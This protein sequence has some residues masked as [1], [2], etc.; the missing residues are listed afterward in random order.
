M[1]KF[2][3]VA[4]SPFEMI[5]NHEGNPAFAMNDKEKLVSQVLTSFFRED[6]F[7]GDN[8]G[9]LIETLKRV[10]E[11]DPG[12]VSNLAIFARREFNMRSVSHVLTGYLA[13]EPAGKPYVKRTLENIIM[14]GDDATEILAFYLETFGK[15]I[16]N[17]LRKGLRDIF[18]KFDAYTLA[19]YKGTGKTV[20]MRDILCLTHPAPNSEEQAKTWKQLL[21]GTLPPAYTWETELS[22]KGNTKET[23]EELIESGKVGYMAMLRNLRNILISAPDNFNQVIRKIADPEEVRKSRQLP[24]R[25]LSAY[26]SIP[27]IGKATDIIA[28]Q[29]ALEI[30]AEIAVENLPKIPGK[31]I[32]AVDVSGSMMDRISKHSDIRCSDISLLM[33]MIANRICEESVVYLF[34]HHIEEFQPPERKELLSA[35]VN[36]DVWGGGTDMSLPFLKMIEDHIDC[37]RIIILSDNECNYQCSITEEDQDPDSYFSWLRS[38]DIETVQTLANRYCK[39]IGHK[40]WIHAVD[41][42]GYG[43]QQFRGSQVN[44]ISGWSEKIFN[45]IPLAEQ[46]IDSLI[47]RIDG[48]Y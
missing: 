24:F 7:Y 30:A 37:D 22:A 9:E 36:M 42:Q 25:F 10:I 13:H 31:T 41:L 1:S 27:Y 19:K 4:S 17:S 40:I 6:K 32:I 47:T 46:G 43:T 15:P 23:W 33:G 48:N 35:V 11:K 16:P 8:S 39:Q 44:Y 38:Q 2:N 21:E 28:L 20:K 12:F 18:P 5:V 29:T 45:F 3:A 26:R 34:D 14:R